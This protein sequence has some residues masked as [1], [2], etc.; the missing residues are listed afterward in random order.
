MVGS[1]SAQ[2][3]PASLQPRGPLPTFGRSESRPSV[4]PERAFWTLS[5]SDTPCTCVITIFGAECMLA[6][7]GTAFE[8]LCGGF[9]FLCRLPAMLHSIR[10]VGL[11][12]AALSYFSPPDLS[13]SSSPRSL[14]YFQT[15]MDNRRGVLAPFG[16]HTSSPGSLL[17]ECFD[18]KLD[19]RCLCPAPVISTCATLIH[20]QIRSAVLVPES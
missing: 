3:D 7:F 8:L 1:V 6:C 10:S 11:V 17:S 13:A 20:E 5:S 2:L 15:S 19:P 14:D 9:P 18:M 4:G 16:L 12:V